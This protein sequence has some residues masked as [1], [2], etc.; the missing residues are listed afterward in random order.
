MSSDEPELEISN[1]TNTSEEEVS[2]QEIR[3]SC[4]QGVNRNQARE[5]ADSDSENLHQPRKRRIAK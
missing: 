5:K 4:Y 1:T 2:F 3:S